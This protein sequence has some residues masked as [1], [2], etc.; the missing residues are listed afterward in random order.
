MTA[1]VGLD[2]SISAFGYAV[3]SSNRFRTAVL[4]V[5]TWTTRIDHDAGKL[6]DRARRVLEL[7][8]NLDALLREFGVQDAYVE[9]LALGMRTGMGTVQTLGRIRGLVEGICLARS[10]TLVEVR[11][12]ALKQAITG[13]KDAS[14]AEV[15]RT[16]RSLYVLDDAW[17]RLDDNATDAVAVAHVGSAR[18]GLDARLSSGVVRYDSV[19]TEEDSW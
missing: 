17:G 7:G 16:M 4:S 10:V 14:K 15:A 18:A 9:S 19:G 13:R 11:P 1:W 8:R 3:M 12:E 2:P 5:G 6:A